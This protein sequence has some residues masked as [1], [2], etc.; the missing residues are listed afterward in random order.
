MIEEP[1]A[2][3][4]KRRIERPAQQSLEALRSVPTPFVVDAMEG[5][6]ALDHE[7]QPLA[8]N[9]TADF[10]FVGSALTCHCGPADN[11]ALFAA[12]KMVD[13]GDVVVAATDRF[14]ATCVTGDQLLALLKNQGAVGF[15]T[16]GLVR[17]VGGILQVDIPVLCRGVTPNAPVANGPGSVGLDITVGGVTVASGDVVVADRDGIVVVPRQQLPTVLDRLGQIKQLEAEMD[18]AVKSGQGFPEHIRA[19]LDSDRVRYV[20]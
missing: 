15:I 18:A 8:E 19:I 11:L 2:V 7:I 13:S 17:D 16:D 10:H 9:A 14:E 5:R 20:D 12:V 6:G 4:I 3:T 1:P